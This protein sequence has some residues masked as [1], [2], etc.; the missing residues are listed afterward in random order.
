MDHQSNLLCIVRESVR[1]LN[2][3]HRCPIIR[4][5]TTTDLLAKRSFNLLKNNVENIHYRSIGIVFDNYL[6]S[7]R[8]PSVQFRTC[9]KMHWWVINRRT[10]DSHQLRRISR[11]VIHV[12][13][14]LQPW[15]WTGLFTWESHHCIYVQDRHRRIPTGDIRR[16]RSGQEGDFFWVSNHVS[17]ISWTDWLNIYDRAQEWMSQWRQAFS[18]HEFDSWRYLDLA[19]YRCGCAHEGTKAQMIDGSAEH[20]MIDRCKTINDSTSVALR[21]RRRIFNLCQVSTRLWPVI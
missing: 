8:L 14:R 10:N 4:Q 9:W 15:I 16:H 1:H 18:L 20:Q 2:R 21:A 11:R 13:R 17:P 7:L 6:F 12:P 5:R 3:G 19:N